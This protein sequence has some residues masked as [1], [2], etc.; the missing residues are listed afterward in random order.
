MTSAAIPLNLDSFLASIE[1]RA[2]RMALLA[3]G[4]HSDA[5]DLVQDAM[6]KLS[7]NY[8]DA[9]A[10]SW[11]P[12]FQRILQNRILDWHRQ[13][14]RR[15]RL[16]VFTRPLDEDAEAEAESQLEQLPEPRDHNPAQLLEL[17]RDTEAALGAIGR[18]PLRQQ[19]AFLLRAWEGLDVR[20]TA[21]AMECSEGAVKSHY[22]RALHNLRQWLQTPAEPK[23]VSL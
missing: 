9:D 23:E 17:A 1:R 21:A 14:Q 3:T 19:Q 22:F 20:A 6:L 13:Q 10:A 11:P 5:L 15:R 12:L 4:N 2:Y 16:F 7:Q 8:G 18:L